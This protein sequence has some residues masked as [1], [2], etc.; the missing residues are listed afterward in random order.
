[1]HVR[2]ETWI[3]R[4]VYSLKGFNSLAYSADLESYNQINLDFGC[5]IAPI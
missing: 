4:L 5:N 1:M 3:L 2:L